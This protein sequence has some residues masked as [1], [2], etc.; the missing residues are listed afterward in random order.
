MAGRQRVPRADGAR[1]LSLLLIER[2]MPGFSASPLP[3]QGWWASDTAQLY[4]DECRV[5]ATNLIG[6]ENM[7]F[8]AIM[9]N[10]QQ[11]DGTIA[12][13][14]VLKPYMFA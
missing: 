8:V 4:F 9:E 7:G 10:F 1:G 12:I 14:E 5:P 3:K 2:G 6:Q 11:P 13:P